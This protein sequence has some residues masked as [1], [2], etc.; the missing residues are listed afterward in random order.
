MSGFLTE[1][2]KEH[3]KS[4]MFTE[5]DVGISYPL[6]FPILD[7]Q[8][9]FKQLITLEDGSVIEQKRIGVP[10]GTFS[11]FIGPSS[12]GKTAAAIQA[13][14]N[15]IA[16]FGP[17]AGCVHFDAENAC[18]P[19]RI[20][21]LTGMSVSEYN[22]IWR[23]IDD[24]AKMTFE[25]ILATLVEIGKKKEADKS[26][27]MYDTGVYSVLDGKE[28]R[29]YIPT[30]V[31]IDSQMKITTENEDLETIAGLT[32]GGRDAIFRGKWYRNC[33]AVTRKYN[34]NVIVINH[35]GND[36]QLQP[37]KGGAKQLTFIPTGKNVPG[38]DKAVFY[39]SSMICWQPINSKDGIKTE[40]DNGYNG[41]PVKA[42]V[43]KSRSGPG[44]KTATLEF[45]QEA[46]FDPRLTLM[47]F[48]K[49]NGI[50]AGR[51]PKCYFADNPEVTFDTRQFITEMARNPEITR[52]LF[53]GCKPLLE[54]LIREPAADNDVIR[55][56]NTKKQTMDF[57]SELYD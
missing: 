33:L 44:G 22:E 12:S 26:R 46:G 18:E 10:A 11:M 39:T 29:Y 7:Q 42:A 6:G 57:M 8:L 23:R 34:I 31:I 50:I 51:N 38:G 24:P 3:E 27:Y 52:A 13:A 30:A 43:C 47:N 49:E 35:L 1:L 4:G 5:T 25:N 17:D 55:G 37:G 53:R 45:I 28:I 36:I 9:G 19:Q 21:D 20:L 2:E 14:Y 16:R 41:V 54:E 32:S 48:A 40:E 56:A 15:I